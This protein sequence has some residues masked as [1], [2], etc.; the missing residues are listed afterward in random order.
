MPK[1]NEIIILIVPCTIVALP[2]P[3]EQQEAP[4]PRS[5][6]LNLSVAAPISRIVVNYPAQLVR[7]FS[8]KFQA[9]ITVYEL[10]LL[11]LD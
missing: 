3:D 9:V 6:T 8:M 10:T 4:V 2:H 7:K 5:D 1:V 11:I